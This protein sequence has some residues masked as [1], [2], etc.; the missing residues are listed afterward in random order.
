MSALT[1]P[2]ILPDAPETRPR[3]HRR[4]INWRHT[5]AALRDPVVVLGILT[6]AVL[7]ILVVVPLSGLV[8]TTLQGEGL[9]AWRDVLASPLSRN[10]FYEPLFNSLVIGFATAVGATLLGG[11]SRLGGVSLLGADGLLGGGADL[12]EP[13]VDLAGQGLAGLGVQVAVHV[14]VAVEQGAE[15]EEVRVAAVTVA[16]VGQQRVDQLAQ[17]HRGGRERAGGPAA[18]GPARA[19]RPGWTGCRRSSR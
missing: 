11:V 4:R 12:L 15:L 5:V 16:A 13:P 2:P 19:G 18:P 3:P 17:R 7:A 1:S 10:L 9:Q 6:A 14:D 8:A